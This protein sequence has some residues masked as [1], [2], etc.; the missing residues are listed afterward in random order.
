MISWSYYGE[1]AWAY[2]FGRGKQIILAYR[3]MFLAFVVLGTVMKLGNVL[4]FSDLMILSMAFPNI[5]GGI[6][7]APK[8]KEALSEYW[9]KLK[10]G[11]FKVYK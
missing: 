8:V 4:D 10:T 1:K 6:I 3:V 9:I 5:I 11:K 7:L 2:L